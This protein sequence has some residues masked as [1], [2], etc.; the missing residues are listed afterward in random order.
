M[1]QYDCCLR[2]IARVGSETRDTSSLLGTTLQVPLRGLFCGAPRLL[3][4]GA[5]P[6]DDTQHPLAPAGRVAAPIPP[7]ESASP[8]CSKG[9]D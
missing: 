1:R 6:A 9:V 8:L 7:V 3:T 4:H 2:S 5:A